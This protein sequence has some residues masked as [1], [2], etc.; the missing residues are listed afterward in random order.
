MRPQII[1]PRVPFIDERTKTISREWFL[2]L[3]ASKRNVDD[4]ETLAA[5]DDS[6]AQATA[7]EALQAAQ[8]LAVQD[9]IKVA[10]PDVSRELQ[11]AQLGIR[12]AVVDPSRDIQDGVLIKYVSSAELDEIRKALDGVSLRI[13]SASNS[14]PIYDHGELDGLS[15]DDHTQ[16]FLSTG[17]RSATFVSTGGLPA[18]NNVSSAPVSTATLY[19]TDVIGATRVSTATV[20]TAS[21]F[22]PTLVST[23]A[24]STGTLRAV[25][26]VSSATISTGTMFGV[27]TS[28]SSFHALVA[29]HVSLRI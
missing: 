7:S 29:A 17:A 25:T 15:G 18:T 6:V 24:V 2:W 21:L 8:T 22:A 4:A 20:S 12:T 13:A 23:A 1:P 26:N 16:Y 5:F 9:A 10:A 14:T 11:D 19:A 3:I 27:A 28:V